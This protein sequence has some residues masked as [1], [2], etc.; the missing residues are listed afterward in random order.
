MQHLSS[1]KLDYFE[2]LSITKKIA[3]LLIQMGDEI[4]L[5]VFRTIDKST[6]SVISE[7]IAGLRN[8][9]KDIAVAVIEE[10]YQLFEASN[11]IQGGGMDYAR[12]LLTRTLPPEEAKRMFDRLSQSLASSNAFNF[13]TSIKPVQLADFIESEHPQTI[14]LIVAHLN[15]TSAAEVLAHFSDELRAK[16]VIRIADLGELSPHIV[17]KVSSLLE[18]KLESFIGSKVEIGGAKAVAEIFNRIGQKVAKDTLAFIEQKNVDLAS[19]IK[20]MMF[21]FDDIISFGDR[22]IKEII[23]AV[24]KEAL[25][26]ALKGSTE[27]MKQKFTANMSSRAAEAFDED[28]S[29]LGAVKVREVEGAQRKI[30]EAIKQL[31]ESGVIEMNSDEEIIE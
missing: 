31:S 14:A 19:E 22:D 26:L 12:D 30:I 29:F 27:D 20:E 10:F 23:K 28:L 8:I 15:P 16:I 3:I 18:T 11:I 24:E 6:L 1:D 13:L 21:I 9:D 2:S 17:K 4:S 25:L 5:S 7:A